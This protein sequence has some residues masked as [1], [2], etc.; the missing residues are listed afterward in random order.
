[1]ET[2]DL[3]GQW[4]R[5]HHCNELRAEHVGQE[6][7]LMGWV[8]RRRDHGGVIFIDLR[9][10]EGITQVVFEPEINPETHA[11]A[12]KLRAEYCI[13]I[14][15]RVRRRP[16]GMENP[17]LPTGEIEVEAKELRILN[18]SKTPPWPLDEDVEVSEVHRLKYRYL[19]LRR[20]QMMEA[21]RFRHQVARLARNFLDEKGFVEVETPFLTKSTP[22][23]ARDYLVPSRLYPG[24]FYALPQS[25]QLFK[26]ILMVAGVDR[27]YQ[28]VR[29]FRDEDLRADRQPEFTQLDLEM[30]F[31]TEQDIMELLEELVRLIFRETLGIEL[32][33]PFPVLSY[34]EAMD[35]Y[36]TDR[37]DLRFGLELVALTDIFRETKFKVFAQVIQKGG[38]IKGLCVPADFSR[39]ELDDLTALANELGAKGLAWI[40]VREENELQSPIVKFFSKEE[41][42]ELLN[43][44]KPEPGSTIFFVADQPSVVNEVLAEL[45]V[46][47]AKRL[48]LIPEGVFKPCWVVDFPLVEWDEEEGRFVAM[49]HPFTSPKEEDLDLLEENPPAVRSR[50]Y[51]LVLNGIEVGGGSIR[52]HR[53]DIQQRVF[54][55][56]KISPEEAQE[57]FGFLLE[58]LE[59]GAPPHGGFAFGF[60]RLV[61]LMLGRKS[62]RDVIA[63]PKTQ[64]AQCLLTGA[65]APVTMTQ[66]TELH[67]LP[68]WDLDKEKKK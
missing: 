56:L 52:I 57:K 31:I 64:R 6:V 11:H 63:F 8:L 1:M 5:T 22:E 49:H 36:G 60:D 46:E 47:L 29:C 58:A 16:E 67:L 10:R 38:I 34:H 37:P 17:K 24:K 68:G 21:L 50:A 59:Y 9:D 61:M 13:A 66:L 51:D 53:S 45:R 62:I 28:I 48:G 32:E 14:K 41:V 2:L 40:K 18:A 35:K 55:L 33:K 27:Y 4:K 15:G 19:D 43:T 20:P 23:G 44:L 3:L 7:T 65:P 42:A 30:S 54:K 12:H 25:P 26:Q 39:K